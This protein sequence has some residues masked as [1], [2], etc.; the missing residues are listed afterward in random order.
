MP[1]LLSVSSSLEKCFQIFHFSNITKELPF[2]A[3]TALIV[4]VDN[5]NHV[6]Y[7]FFMPYTA[8]A[9]PYGEVEIKSLGT[10]DGVLVS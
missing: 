8:R 7:K 6:I 3:F 1:S 4:S 5:K 10:E 2:C 9:V